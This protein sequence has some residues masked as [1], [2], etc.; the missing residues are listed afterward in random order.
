MQYGYPTKV[1]IVDLYN[2]LEPN[3][4]PRH[5]SIGRIMCCKFFLL[6]SGFRFQDFKMGKS[7]IHIRSEKS[8]LLDQM[9]HGM[10]QFN[11]EIALKF[12]EKVKAYKLRIFLIRFTF[13][14]AR[15]STFYYVLINF[16]LLNLQ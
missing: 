9:R 11:D 8:Q 2:Q 10:Y 13:L 1:D 12:N 7:E 3:L 14:G 6:A 5:I 16:N 15:K 4:S